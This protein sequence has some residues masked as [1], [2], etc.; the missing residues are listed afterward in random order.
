MTN[1]N[2]GDY[3]IENKV[4]TTFNVVAYKKPSEF[5]TIR[6]IYSFCI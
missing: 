6:K 4:K 1:E 2:P 3:L 5:P